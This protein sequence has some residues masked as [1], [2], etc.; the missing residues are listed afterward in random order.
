M[1]QLHSAID[2]APWK[3]GRMCVAKAPILVQRNSC[4]PQGMMVPACWPV[5]ECWGEMAFH[6]TKGSPLQED[7]RPPY[8]VCGGGAGGLVCC[9][10]DMSRLSTAST[11]YPSAAYEHRASRKESVRPS[12]DIPPTQ[13]THTWM[14]S[15]TGR[16]PETMDHPNHTH[17]RTLQNPVCVKLSLSLSLSVCVCVCV[18]VPPARPPVCKEMV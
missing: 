15:Q 3:E 8:C 17:A 13:R 7:D 9:G 10:K 2:R 12:R 18:C 4:Q 6:Q 14:R 16:Q 11:T 1:K 5:T